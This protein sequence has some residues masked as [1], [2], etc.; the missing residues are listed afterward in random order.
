MPFLFFVVLFVAYVFSLIKLSC[1]KS[2]TKQRNIIHTWASFSNGIAVLAIYAVINVHVNKDRRVLVNCAMKLEGS[3]AEVHSGPTGKFSK[4]SISSSSLPP[5][6]LQYKVATL[7]YII[8]MVFLRDLVAANT[9]LADIRISNPLA[10]LKEKHTNLSYRNNDYLL[11]DE[12][13]YELIEP[14]TTIFNY[15]TP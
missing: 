12:K 7:E 6:L 1:K 13:E 8:L 5:C 14:G 11:E 10:F 2:E 9:T 4:T 3:A 15:F